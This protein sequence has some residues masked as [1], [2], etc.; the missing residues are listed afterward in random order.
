MFLGS[1]MSLEA[2]A[3]K[4]FLIVDELDSFRFSTKKALKDMGLEKV[5]AAETAQKVITGFKNVNYDVVLCNYELGKGK[6]GQELLEELRYKKLLKFTGLFFIVSAVVEKGKVMGT[7]ENEPDGYLVKPVTPSE[8]ESRLTK[9][10]AMKDA[11]REIDLAL[12]DSAYEEAIELC[13]QKIAAKDRYTVR[14]LKTKAWLLGKIGELDKAKDVYES[15]LQANEFLWAQYGLAK[16]LI[17]QKAYRKAEAILKTIIENDDKQVEAMDLLAKI[18]QKLS[19]PQDAQK[20]V[21]Q[22]ISVSPN[23]LLRQQKLAQLC[24]ENKQEDGAMNAFR[25]MVKLGDQ[26]VYAKPDQYYEFADY[27][28]D[29]VKKGDDPEN[30]AEAREAFE[31]LSKSKKRFSNVDHIEEKAKLM[32]ASVNATLGNMEEAEALFEA[33]MENEDTDVPKLDAGAYQIAAQALSSMGKEDQAESLLEQ[34]ADMAKDNPEL[35]SDIYEQ[36]N[37]GVSEED[38]QQAITINKQGI[39]LYNDGQTGEAATELRA[40]IPLTPRHISLNLNLVQVLL[41]QHKE[42]P[43]DSLIKE[44]RDYLHKVRHIPKDHKEYKRFKY[45]QKQFKDRV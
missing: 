31:L 9:A 40:A 16:V 14:C 15:V 1:P 4:R 41:R 7:I 17:N 44:I 3:K 25:R 38:R 36:F 5:D 35:L 22:A 42:S 21:E 6:N 20:V 10:L 12:D 27:L 43:D 32:A 8:L 26:S 23:S 13:D 39:K 11:M 19:K 29:S 30:T 45:L 37:H 2:Y 24:I 28:A 18:Y 34:A 33:V